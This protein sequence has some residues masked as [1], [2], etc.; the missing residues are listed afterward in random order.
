MVLEK[1]GQVT[2]NRMLMTFIKTTLQD[3]YEKLDR[4]FVAALDKEMAG[5]ADIEK[6]T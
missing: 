1:T 3:S 4:D 5:G 6:V 2:S